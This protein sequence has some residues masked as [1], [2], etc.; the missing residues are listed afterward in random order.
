MVKIARPIRRACRF[1]IASASRPYMGVKQHNDKR[2][3][4]PSHEARFEASRS[5]PMSVKSVA[6]TVASKD[7]I[8]PASQRHVTHSQK[9]NGERPAR[10]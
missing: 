5:D 1:P 4:V 2:Y 6:T 8:I 7:T 9:R 3:D 10:L